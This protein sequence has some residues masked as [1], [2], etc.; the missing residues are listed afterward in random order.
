PV[1][2]W[3][4]PDGSALEAAYFADHPG[5]WTHG[6]WI[7]FH[8]DGSLVI[9]GR[10]DATLNRGGVRM[11]T[12]ELYSIVEE[13]PAVS[14]SL[15]IHLEDVDGGVGELILFIVPSADGAITPA[16]ID[17][18]RH[19]L[20]S[21]LSPRHAPDVVEIVPG[22]PRTRSGKKLEIPVKK[23][24]QG[25]GVDEVLRIDSLDDAGLLEPFIHFGSRHHG[26]P[27]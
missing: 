11:G 23:L 20:R 4:D 26:S 27:T 10:S 1:S 13:H 17:G 25:H 16:V 9:T 18:L 8:D 3:G 19:D 7:M 22:I 15:V 6:D 12:A 2:F 21:R 14:D 5:V 24:L